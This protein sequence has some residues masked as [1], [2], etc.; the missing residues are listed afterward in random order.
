VNKY[1]PLSQQVYNKNILDANLR[2]STKPIGQ[3]QA[4]PDLRQHFGDQTILSSPRPY[5]RGQKFEESPL[6]QNS[7]YNKFSVGHPEWKHI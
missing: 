2:V 7:K 3:G 1:P 6:R 5:E 4:V